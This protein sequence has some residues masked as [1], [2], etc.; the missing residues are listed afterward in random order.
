M[1]AREF[2][3][4]I[5]VFDLLFAGNGVSNILEMLK[6][7]QPIAFV[8]PAETRYFS[9]LVLGNAPDEIVRHSAIEDS[10]TAGHQVNEI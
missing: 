1:N 8:A 2:L 5:P 3:F 9:A 4:A 7:D 6:P 10:R